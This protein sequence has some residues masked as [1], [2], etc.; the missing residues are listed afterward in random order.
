MNF[1]QQIPVNAPAMFREIILN[2]AKLYTNVCADVKQKI[3]HRYRLCCVFFP[4]RSDFIMRIIQDYWSLLWYWGQIIFKLCAWLGLS[5]WRGGE[6]KGI[7]Q[8]MFSSSMIPNSMVPTTFKESVTHWYITLCT[9]VDSELGW[10]FGK[11]A[12]PDFCQSKICSKPF[13]HTRGIRT[14]ASWVLNKKNTDFQ[15]M[16]IAYMHKSL[17]TAEEIIPNLGG[18]VLSETSYV[19]MG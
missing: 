1:P 12:W 17:C 5:L 8:V 11:D 2:K 9:C 15:I 6:A 7:N 4:A 18:K 3:M 14:D 10:S 13:S 19:K 16:C